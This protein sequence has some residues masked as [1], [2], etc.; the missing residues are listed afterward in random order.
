[1]IS[2]VFGGCRGWYHGAN[3]GH[4][5]VMCSALGVEELAAR[6]SWRILAEKIATA[7]QPVL[8]FDYP[9]TGDSTD[10][11][12]E[13]NRFPLW[14][15]SANGAID[16]LRATAG[17]REISLIGLRWGGT[18]AALVAAERD[19]IASLALLEPFVT[20]RDFVREMR[21]T[22]QL[23]PARAGVQSVYDGIEIGGIGFSTS[24]LDAARPVDL[25]TIER[26]PASRVLILSK[27]NGGKTAR[28]AERLQAQGAAVTTKPFEGLELML[29]DPTAARPPGSAWSV[30]ADWIHRAPAPPAPP[31]GRPQAPADRLDSAHWTETPVT[32]GP[33]HNLFGI[34]AEP[35]NPLATSRP[36]LFL[37]AGGVHH[38]GWARQTVTQ[39]RRLAALGVTSLRMSQTGVGETPATAGTP[40]VSFYSEQ[41]QQDVV[42]GVEWLAAHTGRGVAVVGACSGAYQAFHGA[43]RDARITEVVIVNLQCF[44]YTPAIWLELRSWQMTRSY[45]IELKQR[46]QREDSGGAATRTMKLET[47][48]LKVV[49]KV[50]AM[51]QTLMKRYVP[52]KDARGHAETMV[53]R[54][55]A[56]GTRILFVYS[57]DDRGRNELDEHLGVDGCRA[58]ALPGVGLKI[59]AGADHTFTERSSRAEFLLILE[60]FL[61]CQQK[62][63]GGVGA[64]QRG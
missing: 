19:D 38:V 3:G 54:L 9:G 52:G 28:Y 4:A 27:T 58:T 5:V 59:I 25:M 53:R 29:S 60:E 61:G 24:T 44:H 50:S 40:E 26:L 56:R 63:G 20:G 30:V 2:I 33:S 22:A 57:D 39:A 7:G 48:G 36:V 47:L 23:W 32:F 34:L 21:A 15:A 16:W 49:R 42:S 41:G 6:K 10:L 45:E 64:E 8:R 14:L 43:L 12:E 55:A 11:D 31:S 13:M 62:V 17:V 46:L 51:S 35:A 18:L 1:M 37:N